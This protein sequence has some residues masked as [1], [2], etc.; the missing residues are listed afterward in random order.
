MWAV[1]FLP[2]KDSASVRPGLVSSLL[3]VLKAHCSLASATVTR[4]GDSLWPEPINSLPKCC[5]GKPSS[6]F[7]CFSFTLKVHIQIVFTDHL[8]AGDH[9]DLC[10]GGWFQSKCLNQHLL[11]RTHRT[12]RRLLGCSGVI[13]VKGAHKPCPQGASSPVGVAQPLTLGALSLLG[14]IQCQPSWSPQSNGG[15]LG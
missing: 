1:G 11:S 10:L 3:S 8:M 9:R 6:R 2:T 7:V 5:W 14:E 13:E 4:N 15:D 12:Y